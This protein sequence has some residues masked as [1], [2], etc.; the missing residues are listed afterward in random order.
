MQINTLSDRVFRPV[1]VARG[2]LRRAVRDAHPERAVRK[3]GGWSG[4]VC[5]TG[6][7]SNTVIGGIRASGRQLLRGC[8]VDDSG[9]CHY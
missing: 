6:I 9:I 4:A 8:S 7:N 3:S 2:G 5:V 1:F